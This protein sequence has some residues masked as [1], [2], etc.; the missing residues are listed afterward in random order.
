M[1]ETC[2]QAENDWRSENIRLGLKYRAEDGILELY[3]IVCYGYKKNKHSMLVINKK[4]AEVVRDIFD[5]YLEDYSIGGIINKM[6]EKIKV[7]KGKDSWSKK[8]IEST[9]TRQK[10][11]GD[12]AI[13]NSDGE[14]VNK[15]HHSGII[16]KEKF[17]AI[18]L[19]MASRSNVEIG[20]DGKTC[21]KSRKYSS[22]RGEYIY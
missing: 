2:D 12:V 8:G 5:W 19:E 22:K 3:N 20:E 10:Y 16:S 21:R 13:V 14:Y 11:T 17:E 1:I 18:L 7:P 9:L 6:K 4:Q 15:N